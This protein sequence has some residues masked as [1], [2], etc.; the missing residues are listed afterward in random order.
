MKAQSFLIALFC[1][2]I[3]SNFEKNYL[4]PKLTPKDK[5]LKVANV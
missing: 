2:K 3:V 4:N 1:F 5:L